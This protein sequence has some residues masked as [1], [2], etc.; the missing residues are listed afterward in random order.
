MNTIT[1]LFVPPV[2][3]R[4]VKTL[5]EAEAIAEAIPWTAD[6]WY[7]WVKS[8][9]LTLAQKQGDCE[10]KS[11]LGAELIT[12][13]RPERRMLNMI[14]S[15]PTLNHTVLVFDGGF[16]D[17]GELYESPLSPGEI[18]RLL[19]PNTLRAYV[20]EIPDTGKAESIYFEL[21]RKR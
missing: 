19:R 9:G 16:M 4:R 17:N 20:I 12:D 8:P 10:D 13:I 21:R 11:R 6:N 2:P 7:D 1:G 14:C 5:K 15:P 18:A 3:V